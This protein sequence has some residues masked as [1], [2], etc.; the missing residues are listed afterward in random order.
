[1]SLL[2]SFDDTRATAIAVAGGKGANLATLTQ[3]GFPVPAGGVLTP[4]AYR[5]FV[6][7]LA[8]LIEQ[9][10]QIRPDDL[11]T[12][13][14][15]SQQIAQAGE[16]LAVPQR[17]ADAVRAMCV[18]PASRWAVRSSGTLEDTASAAFAGQHDTYLNCVGPDAVLARVRDC[19][20]SLWS[21]RAI[22]YRARLGY[23]HQQVAMAVVIQQMVL[24]DVAG[25]AFSINP[26][27]GD[28]TQVVINANFGLGESV[29]SGEGAVDHLVVDRPTHQV[30][31][32]RIGE[33][34]QRVVAADRLGDGTGGTTVEHLPTDAAA[35][36][37]LQ[38]DQVG[39]VVSLVERVE[40]YYG[41]PQDIEWGMAGGR[42]MLLQSRPI[43]TIPARW[44]R[45]ESAERFPNPVTPLTWDL[46]E[47]GF[48]RSLNHSFQLMG[49]PKF[50]GQWFACF[51]FY[52]YGNQNAV[53]LY[54][55]RSPV[56]VPD[57]NALAPRLPAL[58]E[59]FSWVASLPTQWHESLD[60]YLSTLARYAQE[61][62]DQYDERGLWNYVQR[63]NATG[64]EYFLPNIAISIGHGLLHRSVRALLGMAMAADRADALTA[65]LTACET[66]TTRVNRDL[67]RLA[68]LADDRV[69]SGDGFNPEFQREFRRFIREHGH[70]ETDFD[71]YHPTWGDAPEVVL[72]H[73]RAIRAAG[74]GPD[75]AGGTRDASE[76]A[77]TIAADLPPSVR[78]FARRLIAL[79]REYTALDDEEHYHTTRLAPLLRRGVG[80]LGA[81]LV[82]RGILGTPLDLFFARSEALGAAVATNDGP[83]WSKLATTVAKTKREYEK[84]RTQ[85]PPWVYGATSSSD[86]NSAG[87]DV[88]TGIPGSP[89]IAEGPAY[90]V[91]GTEDFA[92]FPR[93]AVLIA[94]TTNPAWTP[95]FYSAA[96]VIAA[97]GGPLSHGAVTAR[98]VRIPAVMAV[99]DAM[100]AF[101]NG[102]YLRVDGTAGR[103]T[104]VT[105]VTPQGEDTTTR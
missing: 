45:D 96:G 16:T 73:I 63:V 65:E 83:T 29:V 32:S 80:A 52:V 81:R 10:G 31:E 94:R 56:S 104:R 14:R 30:L 57:L 13:T 58:I 103:V 51:D 33:K 91:N 74:L 87:G 47:R 66:M 49:L 100:S 9:V 21:E 70:R 25:V 41:W 37:A 26:V 86:A 43:T 99:R 28:L 18:D 35:Q 3:A 64:T 42:L 71:A 67:R 82:A 1:M 61:P 101:K 90:L 89:G 75:N 4:E 39:D 55:R 53:E 12:I 6:R 79:A 102:D 17:I 92:G 72:D 34:T 11:T 22:A 27:S 20:L 44:T 46:V 105:R 62:L 15:F 76:L 77:A 54:A 40:A 38:P 23:D 85:T 19:W 59:R 78:E 88:W 5:E 98:E 69:G 50:D 60:N 24:C 84:S 93:G 68:A 36:P 7:P 95:L 97:S 8:P 2:L 48:H